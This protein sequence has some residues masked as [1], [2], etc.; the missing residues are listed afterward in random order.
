MSLKNAALLALVGV[1]VLTVLL[2]VNFISTILGVIRDL[3][4]EVALFSS[5][6]RVFASVCVL[7]FLFVFYRKQS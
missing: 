6:V 3:I 4:P 1:A 7:V 5:L 2:V